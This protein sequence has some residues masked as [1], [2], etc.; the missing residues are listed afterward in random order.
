MVTFGWLE[1]IFP[2][3]NGVV[4]YALTLVLQPYNCILDGSHV[5]YVD[6]DVFMLVGKCTIARLAIIGSCNY[7]HVFIPTSLDVSFLEKHRNLQCN[8]GFAFC[9]EKKVSRQGGCK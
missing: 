9:N 6:L 3:L 5:C 4:H 7:F 8:F 2:D 1:L